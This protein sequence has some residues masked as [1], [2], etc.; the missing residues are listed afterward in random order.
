MI[1]KKCREM[2]VDIIT[3][4]QLSIETIYFMIKDI[5]NEVSN[6]YEQ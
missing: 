1:A 4:S 6:V 3:H 2:I 5:Y